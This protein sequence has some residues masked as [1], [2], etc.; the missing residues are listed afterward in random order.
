MPAPVQEGLLGGLLL[1]AA[2]VVPWAVARAVGR[3]GRASFGSDLGVTDLTGLAVA[4]AA[5]GALVWAADALVLSLPAWVFVGTPAV[6][7]YA[8]A[9]YRASLPSLQRAE[10]VYEQ[11]EL[12]SP[13]LAAA[14]S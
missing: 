7:V 11:L 10:P 9:V 5:G 1:V 8:W 4:G 13:H 2:T 3:G 6:L 14:R 12:L